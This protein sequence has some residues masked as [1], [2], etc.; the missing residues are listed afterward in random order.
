MLSTIS[1]D[2][3]L[4]AESKYLI[5]Y[6]VFFVKQRLKNDFEVCSK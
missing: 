6:G 5:K 1:E 3:H 4:L 2:K